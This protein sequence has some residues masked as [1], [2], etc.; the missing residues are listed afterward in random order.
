[1]ASICWLADERPYDERFKNNLEIANEFLVLILSYFGFLFTDYV[2]DPVLRYKFGYFYIALL[3][4]GLFLNISTMMIFSILN[5]IKLR[6][7]KKN[8]ELMVQHQEQVERDAVLFKDQLRK[9]K[10]AFMKQISEIERF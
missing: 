3:A 9:K 7:A 2:P 6:R 1:M 4:F 5:W 8:R 10:D